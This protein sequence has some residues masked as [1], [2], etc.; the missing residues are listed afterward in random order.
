MY[1]RNLK[2][3][4]GKNFFLFGPRGTGKSTWIRQNY[5]HA[6]VFDLLE[7]DLFT[8]LLAQPH[9]LENLLPSQSRHPIVIDE[10]QKIPDLLN[11]VHR[12]I[13]KK[14][15][16]FILTG[17]SA[18]KLRQKGVNLL[19]GRALTHHLYPL[20]V[21]E[22]GKDFSLTKSLQI[23]HLPMAYT[24]SAPEKYLYS[25]VK[26]YLR[27][28]VL[29][30][31]LTRNLGAFARFLESA[32]F[33]Q[34]AVLNISE[35]GRE[36]GVERKV[37][38]NYF[39]ILED[40]LI[41]YRIPVFARRAKRKMIQHPKF[42]FFDVG[43]YRSIRPRGPLDSAEEIEGQALETLFL[44]EIMAINSYENLGYNIYFWRT[45]DDIEID[46]ILYGK[47]GLYAFEI[48]RKAKYQSKD[49]SALKIFLKDY[50]MAKAY[51]LYGGPREYHESG[52]HILPIEKALKNLRSIL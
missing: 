22:L 25:Y 44:Q 43:I 52:I 37:V 29:Q 16:Q 50:P 46:F 3:P 14:K 47:R 6:L 34:A 38:E 30:E 9:R 5:P 10:I 15:Y 33:S 48:K 36:C 13:E 26:T 27:E 35:V 17:S 45:S 18:R 11:E 51:L 49:L 19:G 7:T 28:E 4:L 23:G 39:T 41:A 32:S 24:E 21:T 40:L 42:F 20:T 1:T 8:E 2:P 12:L 31:G